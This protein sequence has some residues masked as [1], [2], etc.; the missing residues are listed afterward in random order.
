MSTTGGRGRRTRSILDLDDDTESPI[1]KRTE[2]K[3]RNMLCSLFLHLP[4]STA[5]CRLLSYKSDFSDDEEEINR[6]LAPVGVESIDLNDSS[7]GDDQDNDDEEEDIQPRR[8]TKSVYMGDG[9]PVANP[10]PRRSLD[11]RNGSRRALKDREKRALEEG[12]EYHGEGVSTTRRRAPSLDGSDVSDSDVERPSL[13]GD[14]PPQR[15]L[16]NR[17]L[18]R[19]KLLMLGDIGVGK[20]SLMRRWTGESVEAEMV[21]TVGV[22]FTTKVVDLKGE[23]LEVKIWD[24]A[25]QER[26]HV[27]THSYYKGCNGILLVYDAENA[28]PKKLHYWIDNIQRHAGHNVEV[29]LL[30]NKIGASLRT[31]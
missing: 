14:R 30:C 1:R 9:G 8:R 29:L 27:I 23:Q 22:D 6:D 28:A 31:H 19:L 17:K 2:G 13:D 7:G 4:S 10:A 5:N 18:R 24:T 11:P 21:S 15:P 16:A 25:G 26:F 20:T 3:L 12:L